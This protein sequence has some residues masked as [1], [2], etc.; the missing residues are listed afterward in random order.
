MAKAASSAKMNALHDM[1]ATVF[2]RVI[3]RYITRLNSM[4]AVIS[5]DVDVSNITDEVIASM[6][7]ESAMPS[8]S[9]MSAITKFLKDNEV[10]FEKDKIDELSATKRALEERRASRPNLANLS[11]VPKVVNES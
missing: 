3:E 9:M 1:T 2:I 11:V 7:D 10:L 6:F 4:D 5:G 8:A